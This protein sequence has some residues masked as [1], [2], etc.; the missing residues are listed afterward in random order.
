MMLQLNIVVF[1]VAFGVVVVIGGQA[2]DD[3]VCGCDKLNRFK[4][5]GEKLGSLF[6]G[7]DQETVNEEC[8]GDANAISRGEDDD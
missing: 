1:V 7:G 6:G 4:S 3:G 5:S 8:K 2:I